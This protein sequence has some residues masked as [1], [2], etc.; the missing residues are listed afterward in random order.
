M[1]VLFQEL[2]RAFIRVVIEKAW[3]LFDDW[4]DGL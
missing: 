1:K 2:L 3:D 4:W